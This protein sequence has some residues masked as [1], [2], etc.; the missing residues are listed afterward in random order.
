MNAYY[1]RKQISAPQPVPQILLDDD[2][3][4]RLKGI[5]KKRCELLEAEGID[6]AFELLQRCITPTSRRAL[7]EKLFKK[8]K[9]NCTSNLE[10]WKD[11]YAKQVDS[12]VKQANL[13]RIKNMDE[14]TAY[15]L[16]Q[17]GIRH[18]DD[19]AKVDKEKVYGLL[20]CMANAQPTFSL[21]DEKR[22]EYFV[23][24]A[25]TV[26]EYYLIGRSR[27][28]TLKQTPS[29]RLLQELKKQQL[30]GQ[31][32]AKLLQALARELASKQITRNFSSTV[33]HIGPEFD[34]PDPD[35]LFR[36]DKQALEGAKV[37]PQGLGYLKDVEEQLPL[38]NIIEGYVLL[39]PSRACAGEEAAAPLP[40]AEVK[41]TGIFGPNM[42][43][44]KKD[45]GPTSY[46]DSQGKFILRMPDL[47]N[48]QEAI[49]ITISQGANKQE[50]IISATDILKH[51]DKAK[52]LN[53]FQNWYRL[54]LQEEEMLRKDANA[55]T[56]QAYKDLLERKEKIAAI[57]RSSDEEQ[58]RDFE[59][60]YKELFTLDNLKADFTAEPFI[61]QEDIF[62]NKV[63]RYS[64]VLP[65]V[66]LLES[67]DQP[68]YLPTDTAP[69]QIFNYSMLQRLVEPTISKT[70][71]RGMVEESI[72]V[73]DFK[74]RLAT[75]P[76]EWPQMSSLG[77][78]YILNMH[79]AWVP[80]GFALGNLLYSLIL[81]PGEEQRLVV[82]ENKQTYSLQD[83]A[84]GSESVS[85]DYRN[86]QLDNTTAAYDYALEQMSLGQSSSKYETKSNS[87]GGHGGFAGFG[88]VFGLSG[89]FSKSSGSASSS[90]SQRNSHNEASNAAQQFQHGIKTASDRIS[91]AQRLSISLATS[92]QS[93]SVATRIIANH[94]HSHA[95]T[96]QYWEVMR[97]YSLETCIEG[98]D[99]VL[100]VPLKLIKF[101]YG[102][103]SALEQ[104]SK[105]GLTQRY[106]ALLSYAD[107]LLPALPG[108][109]R[110]GLRLILK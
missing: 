109:Y 15:L 50:F 58:E 70:S 35:F 33:V 1:T 68:I 8:E 5:D 56:T 80:D 95:M 61:L 2:S 12:W 26:P 99:L 91:Q 85:E 36:Q 24:D 82:R 37:I 108:K 3:L 25:T 110:T 9:P 107:D 48:L 21:V 87:F 94:N 84:E 90:A 32:D 47:Y 100:Y 4:I 81:A 54:C 79:Q 104:A 52:V 44:N 41:L 22:F 45:F 14:D 93:D 17:M 57:I 106:A 42:D 69:S 55:A 105:E 92:E 18:E 103:D 73:D 39:I 96:I 19:L 28:T 13:L 65:Q 43:K 51:V 29:S 40:N 23:Q 59:I 83:T 66:K 16:V 31:V 88:A 76:Q 27:M 98:V 63:S 30:K 101:A 20:S 74:S 6:S 49:T 77:I 38:P 102:E 86:N 78:G 64:S 72:D 89:S 53:A 7:G 67:N 10:A 11:N 97:R 75:K 62:K 60:I 46:T 71:G 34:D